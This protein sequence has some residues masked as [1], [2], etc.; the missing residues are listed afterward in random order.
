MP[1]VNRS[2]RC[3]AADAHVAQ[4]LLENKGLPMTSKVYYNKH[5]GSRLLSS[6]GR[7]I[8]KNLASNGLCEF[9]PP[10]AI[11]STSNVT[12]EVPGILSRARL[13]HPA[14]NAV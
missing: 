3:A 14:L 9:G 12:E 6:P 1:L 2:P 11:S 4:G 8:N 5:L 13:I 7:A 10:S